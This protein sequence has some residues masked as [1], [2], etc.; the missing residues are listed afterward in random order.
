MGVPVALNYYF[1]LV[2]VGE[3]VA[4]VVHL[5]HGVDFQEEVKTKQV[6]HYEGVVD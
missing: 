2:G 6:P 3:E 1:L 5:P 4:E